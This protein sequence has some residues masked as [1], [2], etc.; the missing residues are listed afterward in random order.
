[1]ETSKLLSLRLGFSTSESREI[2]LLGLEKYLEKAFEF[3]NELLEPAFLATIPKNQ[4]EYALLQKALKQEKE[5]KAELKE[6]SKKRLKKSEKKDQE[7]KDRM[8]EM[9]SGEKVNKIKYKAFIL[10]RCYNAKFPL[11][12]KINLFWSNHFV[13]TFQSVKLIYWIH[14]HYA[15]INNHALGNYKNLVKEIIMS[16]AMIKYLN[17]DQNVK[18]K[19]N[20]NLGR[21]LLELFT[22]GEGNYTEADIKNVARSLAGLSVGETGGVYRIK[23]MDNSIKTIFGKS[24]NFHLDEVLEL[25][26][27]Q[28]NTPFFIAEKILKWFY[29]D[30]PTKESIKYYGNYLKENNY[31]L[32]PFYKHLFIKESMQD[33]GGTQI[34]NPL[35]FTFQTIKSLNNTKPNFE[36]IARFI[37]D[38]G[39]DIYDQVNVKGWKGGNYWL[40]SSIF[41]RRQQFIDGIFESSM[42]K[43]EKRK[44]RNKIDLN[45][46]IS[47]YL[48]F[49]NSKSLSKA[50]IDEFISFSD[51]E[52]IE[53]INDILPYDFNPKSENGESGIKRLLSILFKK[54]E[55]QII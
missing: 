48:K 16:N 4:R 22:L 24:G 9:T 8:N 2:Q 46:D 47:E 19:I 35:I 30:A 34:K 52:T 25:I 17:N 45:I 20:E 5:E 12:E 7:N 3:Q 11:R 38:Q 36:Q 14:Q 43:E 31:E 6:D 40:S 29:D 27:D 23:A 37:G 26:F 10:E 50:I 44:A 13:S 51:Q 33:K 21:E 53:D 41:L 18:N 42:M 49:E 1:M 28:P 39:M 15:I 55:Y 32:K 54:P